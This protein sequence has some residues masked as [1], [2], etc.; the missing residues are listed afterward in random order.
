MRV[1]ANPLAASAFA[2]AGP[3]PIGSIV[4]KEKRASAD[5]PEPYAVAFMI[6][7]AESERPESGGWEFRFFP[8]RPAGSL[9][10]CVE[11]HRAGGT[12]DF[13]FTRLPLS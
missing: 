10:G 2:E 13:V 1:Y 7:R 6:K 9:Q 5:N 3:F 11:C 4:A 8:E 12:K